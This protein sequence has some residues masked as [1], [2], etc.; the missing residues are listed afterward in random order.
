MRDTG[1]DARYVNPDT[2]HQTF[3]MLMSAKRR[4]VGV[5]KSTFAVWAA[6][7]GNCNQGKVVQR[8]ES[9]RTNQA[10]SQ[11]RLAGAASIRIQS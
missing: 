1:L 6:D 2:G 11:Q 7:L 9:P 10:V 8:T 3:C 5:S 4:T